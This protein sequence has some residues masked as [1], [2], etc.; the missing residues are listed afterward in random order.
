MNKTGDKIFAVINSII[1]SGFFFLASILTIDATTSNLVSAQR[2]LV[3]SAVIGLISCWVKIRISSRPWKMVLLL[4]S[5]A[6][7]YVVAFMYIAP[8]L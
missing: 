5:F 8:N 7:W 3:L 2:F 4:L 1:M 6:P